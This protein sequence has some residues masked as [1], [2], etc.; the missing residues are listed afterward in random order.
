MEQSSMLES[1]ALMAFPIRL[2]AA[3]ETDLVEVAMNVVVIILIDWLLVQLGIF[4]ASD[5]T[6]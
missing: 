5:G 3:V 1:I 6:V 4:Y 2:K